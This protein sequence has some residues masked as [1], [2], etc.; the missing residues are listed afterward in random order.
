[1]VVILRKKTCIV[2]DEL[3]LDKLSR[4]KKRKYKIELW[5]DIRDQKPK[6]QESSKN[7]FMVQIN[8]L[9]RKII[10]DN[11]GLNKDAQN[12]RVWITTAGKTKTKI[13]LRYFRT[14]I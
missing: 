10:A 14:S 5:Q 9:K 6:L 3:F 1:M 4:I 2:E 8:I 13:Y 12:Y 7:L 11:M